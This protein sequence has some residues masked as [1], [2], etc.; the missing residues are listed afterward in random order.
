MLRV[1]VCQA[2]ILF[3]PIDYEAYEFRG[4]GASDDALSVGLSLIIVTGLSAVSWWAGIL[5]LS[6]LL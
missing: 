4:Y 3:E 6:A 1:F 5:S 2:S